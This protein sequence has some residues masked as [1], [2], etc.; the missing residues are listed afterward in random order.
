MCTH[1]SREW[2]LVMGQAR[3]WP[4][5][6]HPTVHNTWASTFSLNLPSLHWAL[7]HGGLWKVWVSTSS[8]WTHWA[9]PWPQPPPSQVRDLWRCYW[10]KQTWTRERCD[11]TLSPAKNGVCARACQSNCMAGR[12]HVACLQPGTKPCA[13][14]WNSCLLFL[15]ITQE[16]NGG[17]AK[18][19]YIF[20]KRE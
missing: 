12:S 13:P 2:K 18:T 5:F 10:E 4:A 15:Q 11:E 6:P 3:P 19:I 14:N 20:V 8:H 17:S 1:N 16:P 9:L 7:R